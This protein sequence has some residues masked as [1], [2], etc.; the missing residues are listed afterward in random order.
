MRIVWFLLYE[1]H[2]GCFFARLL[3]GLE[4]VRL[5]DEKSMHKY[6]KIAPKV[7]LKTCRFSLSFFDRFLVNFWW[8]LAS[9]KCSKMIKNRTFFP[10]LEPHSH[11]FGHVGSSFASCAPFGL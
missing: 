7:V 10:A 8:I 6:T 4:K 11:N 2:L 1:S 3:S 9:K 5:F